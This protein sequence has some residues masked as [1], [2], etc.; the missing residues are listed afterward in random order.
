MSA[1]IFSNGFWP[2]SFMGGFDRNFATSFSLMSA[3]NRAMAYTPS[4]R[5]NRD[6]S[7][8]K[9]QGMWEKKSLRVDKCSHR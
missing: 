9:I 1:R 6:K 2:L 3:L 4:N 8:T 7:R 5:S